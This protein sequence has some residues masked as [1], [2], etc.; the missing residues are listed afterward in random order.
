[1]PVSVYNVPVPGSALEHQKFVVRWK[2]TNEEDQARLR[3]GHFKIQINGHNRCTLRPWNY[4]NLVQPHV[5]NFP[6]VEDT[7]MYVVDATPLLHGAYNTVNT[8]QVVVVMT[9]AITAP[10]DIWLTPCVAAVDDIIT[11]S[12]TPK[13]AL[14]LAYSA[15]RS[16]VTL[17]GTTL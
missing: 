13:K 7:G 11:Q 17:N 10:I 15:G 14:A 16:N 9:H 4:F 12:P 3:E 1:M 5:H 2:A 6:I 8:V